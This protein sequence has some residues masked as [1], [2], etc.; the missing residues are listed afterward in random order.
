MRKMLFAAAFVAVTG[1]ICFAGT[2]AVLAPGGVEILIDKDSCKVVRFAARELAD[3][4]RQ[5]FGREVPTVTAPTAGR[6]QIVIGMNDW[7]RMAGI[8]TNG[9]VRDEFIIKADSG[10]VYIVGR[11]NPR[12]DLDWVLGHGGKMAMLKEKATVFGVYEFLERFAGV[13]FY[14]PGEL[15]TIVPKKETIEI[16]EG[17]INVKPDYTSRYLMAWNGEYF[18]S[19]P[20]DA[21][22]TLNY[23]RLRFETETVPCCHGSN[24][25]GYLKRFAKTHP[26]YFALLPSGERSNDPTAAHPGQLCWSSA[27]TE[28]IYRDAKSYLTGEG[29]EI[30]GIPPY[31]KTNSQYAWGGNCSGRKYVDIMP[32]DSF[33]KCRCEKCQAAFKSDR[34]YATELIWGTVD[35]LAR[36]LTDEGVPGTLTM[37]AYGPY[38]RVPAFDLAP[39]IEVMVA[40]MGPWS[41]RNPQKLA[42]DNADIVSWAKKLGHKVW[43]WN[44]PNKWGDLMIRTI[45]IPQMTPRAYAAYYRQQAPWIR[46]AFAESETD[47]Y[48]FNYLNYYVFSKV[49]W[50]NDVDVEKLLAEHFELMF[51]AAVTE[52]AELYATLEDK[53]MTGVMGSTVD[54]PLGPVTKVPPD[55]ELWGRVYSPS[56]LAWFD[57]ILKAA[58]AKVAF[59]SL[60]ARRIALVRKEFYEPLASSEAAYRAVTDGVKN[61]RYVADG[62]TTVELVPLIVGQRTPRETVRTVVTAVREGELLKVTFD[63]EEPRMAER[64]AAEHEPDDPQL[65]E[66]DCVELVLNPSGDLKTYYH[67]ILNSEGS[68]SDARQTSGGKGDLSWQSGMKVKVVRGEKSWRAEIEVPLS[69]FPDHAKVFPVEFARERNLKVSQGYEH[70]YH[71]SPYARGFHHIEN[72]GKLV[73]E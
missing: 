3:I 14:F 48:F 22:K 29:P 5:T 63:C 4:L 42:A 10:R 32:Q 12:D 27:V 67:L 7:S 25:F 70:L 66:D 30:R 55:S 15:G 58:S 61:L 45:G 69:A 36:R 72:F 34:H 16:P 17:V 1:G 39:N 51:G 9:L 47:R 24:Q 18:E 50:D 52:M 64:A 43:L 57:G 2:G 62:K 37:M 41:V 44:Y 8:S 60:E 46:G 20:D 40:R 56:F 11:D 13:R 68:W 49:C 54:T 71:W 53:W 23:I 33:A 59:G 26:E 19:D 38:G 6:S 21:K 65:W 35:R 28:E 73:I 31:F